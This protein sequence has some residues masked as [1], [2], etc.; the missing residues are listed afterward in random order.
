MLRALIALHG[1]TGTSRAL[2]TKR[3]KA[4]EVANDL[5]GPFIG[6]GIHDDDAIRFTRLA[7]DGIQRYAE[8]RGTI[9]GGDDN[10]IWKRRHDKK[11]EWGAALDLPR[12]L[13]A[14]VS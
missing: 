7:R 4:G 3:Q 5:M 13:K 8:F 2:I 6:R 14:Q 11:D 12:K 9:K 10:A 1:G